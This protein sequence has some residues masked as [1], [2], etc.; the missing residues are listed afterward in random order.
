[1][2]DIPQLDSGSEG[3]EV[4]EAFDKSRLIISGNSTSLARWHAKMGPQP[5]PFIAGLSSLSVDGGQIML[6]DIIIEKLFPIAYI[7][8]SK[9]SREGPWNEDEERV[10]ADQWREKYQAESTSLREKLSKRLE[11]IEDLV[12]T[13]VSAAQDVEDPVE[14]ESASQHLGM[15][16]TDTIRYSA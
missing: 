13:L 3:A 11:G 5:E 12:E 7:N 10:R 6:M 15:D 1:M 14:S 16:L 4:L 8:A 9:G 2:S